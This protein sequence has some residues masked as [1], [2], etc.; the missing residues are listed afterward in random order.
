MPDARFKR[1]LGTAFAQL[2]LSLAVQ[3]AGGVGTRDAS[4]FGFSVQLFTTPSL[5][6][7]LLPRLLLSRILLALD[8]CL[9]H[10]ATEPPPDP[11]GAENGMTFELARQRAAWPERLDDGVACDELGVIG[12]EAT[13]LVYRRYDFMLRDFEYCLN[14]EGVASRH[15]RSSRLLRRWM[16]VLTYVQL[17]DPQVRELHTHVELE[18]HAWLQA[19]HLHLSLS[20]AF[21]AVLKPLTDLLPPLDLAGAAA[22]QAIAVTPANVLPPPSLLSPEAWQAARRDAA[23]IGDA[24]LCAL[25]RWLSR[26]DLLLTRT[27]AIAWPG[28]AGGWLQLAPLRAQAQR[29]IERFGVKANGPDSAA[30]SLSGGNLQKFIVGREIDAKPA[31]FIVSQPT[32]GVDVG[33]SAQIRGAI[34]T[35]R[36]A[37][38]AVLV[39]S[40]ELDEL[41]EI[42]DRLQVI[43][44]GKLSPSIAAG[45]ATVAQMGEWMSGLWE[46]QA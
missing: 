26:S 18:H 7:A 20:G 28:F 17:A 36:D 34:L 39:V 12:C 41:F 23:A 5:V 22:A 8:Y 3:Y 40:E 16:G 38:C 45:Q 29:I 15:A 44:H 14:I 24:A 37:G 35:L 4:P 25:C 19:F 10:A 30:R 31:L 27:E 32:W 42:C 2:Y 9:H 11:H 33:A 1:V 13:A 6:A 21:G 46:A 43:A